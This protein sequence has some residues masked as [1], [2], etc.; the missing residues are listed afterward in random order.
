MPSHLKTTHSMSFF[1][2]AR[3]IFVVLLACKPIAGARNRSSRRQALHKALSGGP[4]EPQHKILGKRYRKE[5]YKEQEGHGLLSL[6]NVEKRAMLIIPEPLT[7]DAPPPPPED[8]ADDDNDGDEGRLSSAPSISAGSNKDVSSSSIELAQDKEEE[9][10]SLPENESHDKGILKEKT[11]A[12][13]RDE[14]R[15]GDIRRR[16]T[17]IVPEPLTDDAPPPPPEGDADDDNNGDGGR[18]SSAASTSR[19]GEQA[20]DTETNAS[21]ITSSILIIPSSQSNKSSNGG[22]GDT[23]NLPP[24][25]I[26]VPDYILNTGK[27]PLVTDRGG[28]NDENRVVKLQRESPESPIKQRE[29]EDRQ[30]TIQQERKIKDAD[31]EEMDDEE[32]WDELESDKD[33]SAGETLVSADSAITNGGRI[34]NLAN[35]SAFFL[36]GGLLLILAYHLSRRVRPSPDVTAL[37]TQ[38]QLNM[39]SPRITFASVAQS[40]SGT[41]AAPPVFH[42][43]PTYTKRANESQGR[44]R[45]RSSSF[46]LSSPPSASTT[47]ASASP[48]YQQ[49]RRGSS[50]N[51]LRLQHLN[52]HNLAQGPPSSTLHRNISP[53]QEVD[54][55]G[56]GAAE[57]RGMSIYREAPCSACGLQPRTHALVPCSHL[58]CESCASTAS[59]C[60]TCKSAVVSRNWVMSPSR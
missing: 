55:S 14:R 51:P 21:N 53:E 27:G 25:V 3:T 57:V 44:G 30:K 8:N 6:D 11:D 47:G 10:D 32:G 22:D 35:I 43:A 37:D 7:D 60:V 2:L 24:I 29:G 46:T 33:G 16:S 5:L 26:P 4:R 18:F 41:Q 59:F 31:D 38:P 39:A 28:I 50:T 13:G 45:S 19:R 12:P 20:E 42:L 1:C 9:P 17:L 56:Q 34:S 54:I 52:H 15:K 40:T 48:S 36:F 23:H 58:V 49:G